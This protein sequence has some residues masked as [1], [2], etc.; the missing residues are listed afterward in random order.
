MINLLKKSCRISLLFLCSAWSAV[1]QEKPGFTWE[2]ALPR[3][4]TPGFYQIPITPAI[5]AR[6]Y[7]NG[8]WDIRVYGDSAEIPYLVTQFFE[9]VA[10]G[11]FKA[12]PMPKM[13]SVPGR[14]R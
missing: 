12:Y 9:V 4:T 1:G 11:D 2:A 13:E 8:E 7:R 10:S 6:A 14:R 3:V 5:A